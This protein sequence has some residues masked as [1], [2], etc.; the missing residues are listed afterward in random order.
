MV[1]RIAFEC[2]QISG[3]IS[4]MPLI[5]DAICLGGRR[6]PRGFLRPIV[7]LLST[8]LLI[9]TLEKC[10]VTLQ[11]T[12]IDLDDCQILS[13]DKRVLE[14]RSLFVCALFYL[15]LFFYLRERNSTPNKIAWYHFLFRCQSHV[16][17]RHKC[18]LYL[19]LLRYTRVRQFR[20]IDIVI[21]HNRCGCIIIV[22]KMV[23][24]VALAERSLTFTSYVCGFGRAF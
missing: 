24:F 11:K 3:E 8:D 7:R 4:K 14:S 21:R 5:E 15:L 16:R 22:Q 1:L 10:S 23:L 18:L 9:G 13:Q 19:F 20:H 2:H 12:Q 6:P 17:V